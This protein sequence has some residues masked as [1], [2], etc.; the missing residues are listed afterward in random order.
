ML[1]VDETNAAEVAKAVKDEAARSGV[2][3]ESGDDASPTIDI[4]AIAG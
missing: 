4:P 2:A 1:M 3:Q